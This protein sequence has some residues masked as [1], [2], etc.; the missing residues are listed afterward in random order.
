MSME[1]CQKLSE[2]ANM[3]QV[4]NPLEWVRQNCDTVKVFFAGYSCKQIENFISPCQDGKFKYMKKNLKKYIK[5]INKND[6]S[7]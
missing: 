7:M 1:N 5:S 4:R 3:Y 2:F 6:T